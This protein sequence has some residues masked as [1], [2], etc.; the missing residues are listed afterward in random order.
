MIFTDFKGQVFEK[1]DNSPIGWR[2][3]AYSLVEN[4]K[5]LLLVKQPYSD[6]YELPGGGIETD[7][8]LFDALSREFYEETGVD[9]ANVAK[10]PLYT[11]ESFFY[12]DSYENPFFHS[13]C[14][15]F[16][17]TITDETFQSLK[18]S[19]ELNRSFLPFEMISKENTQ[20][21]HFEA[22]QKY[23]ISIT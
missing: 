14:L 20:E 23:L 16:S 12:N 9:L 22:I 19:S 21:M 1:P 10:V 13:F 6:K 11:H 5:H 3:S 18:N 15:F 4:N 7:E 8:M 17:A 2:L